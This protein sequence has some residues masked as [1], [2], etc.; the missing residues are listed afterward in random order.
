MRNLYLEEGEYYH[1]YN[2][3][4]DKKDIFLSDRDYVRFLFLI[5]Y[6]QAELSF[7]NIERYISRFLNGG[8]FGVDGNT[9]KSIL[10]NRYVEVVSFCLMPNHF[11]ILVKNLE[12]DGVS[13]Y[14]HRIG[15]SYTKFFNLKYG[16]SGHLFQGSFKSVHVE[17]NEHLLYLSAY[18]H[19]N[20]R[21]LKGWKNKED[22]YSWSS[23]K[24][25]LN[26]KNEEIL[27]SK[28]I[29]LDQFDNIKDY[30]KY[31]DTSIAKEQ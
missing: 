12:K 18:I 21:E 5:L 7:Y 31:V 14:M 19:R 3:G 30:R 13:K 6:F 4:N 20:P 24:N 2:R 23:F 15:V 11:H 8:N 26:A 25:Y 22:I 28:D 1:I 9:I 17:D 16:K 29:I 10:K 27:I